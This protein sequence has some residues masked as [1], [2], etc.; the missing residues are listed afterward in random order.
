MQAANW[1]P[2]Q[3]PDRLLTC[4]PP[5]PTPSHVSQSLKLLFLH[6][7]L[8]PEY[9]PTPSCPPSCSSTT[10]EN[11]NT[12]YKGN[13]TR[14]E[15]LR[16]RQRDCRHVTCHGFISHFRK[17]PNAS[18]VLCSGYCFLFVC[19]VGFYFIFYLLKRGQ[20]KQQMYSN[21]P[22]AECLPSMYRDDGDVTESKMKK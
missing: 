22:G 16:G 21:S 8:T 13:T 19:L 9:I 14:K 15:C 20:W 3:S 4:Q 5:H 10:P 6:S 18:L 12:A 11:L 17:K 7:S 1:A 2:P